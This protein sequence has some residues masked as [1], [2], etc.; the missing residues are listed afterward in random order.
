M[1]ALALDNIRGTEKLF[2]SKKTG[3][4]SV[5]ATARSALEALGEA[6]WLAEPDVDRKERLGR[7]IN[8][9][10]LSLRGSQWFIDKGNVDREYLLVTFGPCSPRT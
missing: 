8:M 6:Y 5:W 2:V 1:A 7:V 9:R 10:L 4:F 3:V